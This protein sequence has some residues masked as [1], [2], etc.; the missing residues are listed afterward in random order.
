MTNCYPLKRRF[1]DSQT[2]II[3]NSVVIS[4]VGI[5]RVVCKNKIAEHV[6]VS[7]EI[8][9]HFCRYWVCTV[10]VWLGVGGWIN[11]DSDSR[12]CMY[13][14]FLRATYIAFI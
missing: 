8:K 4:S 3:T 12:C 13:S 7:R 10:C 5:K 9:Y 6:I 1:R 11:R 14:L 2:V